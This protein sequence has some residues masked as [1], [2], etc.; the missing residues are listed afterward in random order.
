MAEIQKT[1]IYIDKENIEEAEFMSRSFVNKE[2]KT[3][4]YLN[5]LGAEAVMKYINSEGIDT[6]NIYNLHSLSKIIEKYDIADI[7]LPNIHIDVRVVFDKKQI[8]IPKSHF[9]NNLTPDVYA[10]VIFSK[11]FETAEFIGY[12]EPSKIDKQKAN[13]DYYFIESEQLISAETFIKYINNYTGKTQQSLS[14]EDILLG[15]QLSVALADHNTT[16]SEEKELIRLLL[17]SDILRESVLE[18]ENFETLA[19][20]AANEVVKTS[21][22]SIENQEDLLGESMLEESINIEEASP[23]EE[24]P[25]QDIEEPLTLEPEIPEETIE[26]SVPAIEQ[27]DNPESVT[28][29]EISTIEPKTEENTNLS[30]DDILD[31]TIASIDEPEPITNI[32]D[33]ASEQTKD[34]NKKTNTAGEIIKTTAQAAAEIAG[35]AAATAAGAAAAEIAAS[36]AAGAAVS[37]GAMKLAGVSGE[38][39]DNI[40]DENIHKQSENLDKIDTELI[41]KNAD[42]IEI[43]AE[44]EA[45]GKMAASKEEENFQNEQSAEFAPKDLSTLNKVKTIASETQE[46]HFVHETI[47]MSEMETVENDLYAKETDS[48][49]DIGTL[50]DI[51]AVKK[52]EEE[53]TEDQILS[54]S[55]VV[56]L[57]DAMEYSINEDG[58]STF[59]NIL[60]NKNVPP[61]ENLENLVDIAPLVDDDNIIGSLNFDENVE[62][63]TTNENNSSDEII[64]NEDEIMPDLAMDAPEL[65]E[66]INLE[67]VNLDAISDKLDAMMEEELIQNSLNETLEAEN[68]EET[69]EQA[70]NEIINKN[71]DDTN[72]EDFPSEL[73]E[74]ETGDNIPQQNPEET[75]EEIITENN[76][77]INDSEE[78]SIEDFE[79]MFGDDESSEELKDNASIDDF[80]GITN[81]AAVDAADTTLPETPSETMSEEITEEDAKEPT[82]AN[83]FNVI[84]N[85]TA[86]SDKTFK[87][88][89]IKIDIND[90][91]DLELEGPE[92]L[93]ELYDAQSPIPGE[94]LLNNPGRMSATNNDS[95][96]PAGKILGFVGIL[97]TLVIVG[98]IGFGV[99]KMFKAPKE[100]APQP[101]TDDTSSL[102][103]DAIKTDNNDTLNVDQNNVVSMDNNTNALASTA[104]TAVTNQSAVTAARTSGTATAFV[105][106]KKLS[107]EVPDYISYN[108]EFKQ[109]FQSAGKSLKNALTADLLLAT[110]YIY[111]SP[112]KISVTFNKDGSFKNSQIINSSGS[113]QIDSIVLQTVNQTFKVLKAPNSIGNDQST[114]AILKIYF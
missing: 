45:I 69:Q 71:N 55:E 9:E 63:I 26:A 52:K 83:T 54:E 77:E 42:A 104:G 80:L 72:E 31:Q 110:D 46:Q 112:V 56:E 97:I 47:D 12:C 90:E 78:L 58:S 93:E 13:N 22:T 23:I 11:D 43:T 95:K 100:E 105:E 34:E 32:E 16:K 106:I 15:R 51:D 79:K 85:T 67:E 109:Y 92:S 40:V 8:F 66:D 28:N 24:E 30:V 61:Q 14:E 84:E 94:A 62:P 107:W 48:G 99:A 103:M 60:E 29:E 91:K 98:A 87:V 86:I 27:N 21:D 39:I 73:F 113:T 7:L 25:V 76:S 37:D 50:K 82:G 70:E 53:L 6:E 5:V 19:Y 88:G 44:A 75:S 59:D 20:N 3:R 49:V 74:N 57:P 96:S 1:L 38:I 10:F 35:A 64:N 65:S 36:A 18:F 89:E 4:A 108:A 41:G 2:L 102:N 114:T 81:E 33:S 101:I 68:K 111:S 17:A